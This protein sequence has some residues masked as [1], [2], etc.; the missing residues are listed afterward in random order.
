MQNRRADTFH[1]HV[2]FDSESR[3]SAAAL[4][5]ALLRDLPPSVHVSRLVDRPIGPHPF[6]MFE[7]GFSFADYP[8]VRAYLESHH[9]PHSVLIHQVTDDEVWDHTEGAEWIGVPVTLDIDFL[10]KFMAGTASGVSQS[11]PFARKGE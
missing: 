2:Y 4:Q 3:A 10:R 8:V 6:P 5:S 1:S 7:L 11:V 9:G